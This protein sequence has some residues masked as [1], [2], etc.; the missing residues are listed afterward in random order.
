MFATHIFT[1]NRAPWL[2]CTSCN[3]DLMV[4]QAFIVF[5]LFLASPCDLLRPLRFYL[6]AGPR[7][8]LPADPCV[9]IYLASAR[10]SWQAQEQRWKHCSVPPALLK[11]GEFL[12]LSQDL[13]R[14]LPDCS[15][16]KDSS[17][18]SDNLQLSKGNRAALRTL[19]KALTSEIREAA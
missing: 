19:K 17:R 6:P 5:E 16:T 2:L 13:R 9:S 11:P 14:Q 10:A 7:F 15:L 18:S 1:L 12:E 3:T 8:Y 4:Q